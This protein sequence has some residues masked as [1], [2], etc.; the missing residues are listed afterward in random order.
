MPIIFG[1]ISRNDKLKD[2]EDPIINTAKKL[3]NSSLE[4]IEPQIN[5]IIGYS[6]ENNIITS[7]TNGKQQ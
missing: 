3:Y 4:V 5:T 1:C 6:N 7:N 2:I